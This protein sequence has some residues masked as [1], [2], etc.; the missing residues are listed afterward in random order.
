MLVD[1][2]LF[3]MSELL[4]RSLSLTGLRKLGEGGGHTSLIIGH[5]TICK[6][7]SFSFGIRKLCQT[8][9]SV[10]FVTTA[11]YNTN[12]FFVLVAAGALLSQLEIDTQHYV[13][14]KDSNA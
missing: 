4:V 6:S 8:R 12:K 14:A 1:G 3:M 11:G 13:E 9:R 10:V 2:L 5:L 7:D